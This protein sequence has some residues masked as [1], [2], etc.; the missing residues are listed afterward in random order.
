MIGIA[1]IKVVEA[2]DTKDY[3]VSTLLLE[4]CAP[5]FAKLVCE[6]TGDDGIFEVTECQITTFD[7]FT[8]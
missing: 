1:K 5:S 8:A 4:K 2:L 6:N 3:F 7:I